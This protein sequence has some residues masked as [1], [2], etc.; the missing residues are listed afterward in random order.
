MADRSMKR[1]LGIIDDVLV[2]VVKFILPADFVILDCEVDYEVS[3][4]LGRPFLATGKALVDVE[5]RELT[6]RVGDEKDPLEVVLLNLDINEDANRVEC[7][8]VLYGMG[9]YSYEPRK[10]SLDLENRKT[11]PTKPSIEEPLVLGLKPL[12][13]HLRKGSE[14]QVADHLSRFEE[15]GRPRD[16][17]E[18]NDPFPNEQLLSVSMNDMPWFADVANFLVTGIIPCELSSNQRKKLKREILDFYWDE[19][20]LFKIYTDG[21]IRRCVPE[22]KQLSILE[23]FHSSPYGVHHGEARTASKVL[24]CGFY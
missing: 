3:I 20:Y 7:V 23:A 12:P 14:N 17:L 9:S 15:E 1:P 24:S 11:P 6:F 8:N 4:I 19:P 13:P 5:A 10:L 2:H 16:G 18:I 21:V 22:E